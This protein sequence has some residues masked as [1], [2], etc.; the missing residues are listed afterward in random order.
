MA[1]STPT[2]A[3]KYHILH[4][5]ISPAAILPRSSLI[6]PANTSITIIPPTTPCNPKSILSKTST[7]SPYHADGDGTTSLPVN[8][9]NLVNP[10]CSISGSRDIRDRRDLR[11]GESRRTDIQVIRGE[12][13][14][15]VVQQFVLI[16]VRLDLSVA[17]GPSRSDGPPEIHNHST[18]SHISIL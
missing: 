17:D 16:R 2:P 10:V 6:L 7:R 4:S 14:Q 15:V 11:D 9:V 8:P 18:T 1:H 13:W 12:S 5:L 3:K